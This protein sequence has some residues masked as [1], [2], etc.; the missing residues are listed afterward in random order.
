MSENHKEVQELTSGDDDQ[1]NPQQHQ[2]QINET[3]GRVEGDVNGLDQRQNREVP[4]ETNEES[5]FGNLGAGGYSEF[6]TRTMEWEPLDQGNGD[7]PQVSLTNEN[8]E[9]EMSLGTGLELKQQGLEQENQNQENE[10]VQDQ[11]QED[12]QVQDQ[13]QENQQQQYHDQEGTN[14]QQEQQLDYQDQD[15]EN[16]DDINTSTL[17]PLQPNQSFTTPLKSLPPLKDIELIT[18]PKAFSVAKDAD[19]DVPNVSSSPLITAKNTQMDPGQGGDNHPKSN[20][21]NQ[22][23]D[24]DIER[25][26]VR[27][28]LGVS[29]QDLNSLSTDVISKMHKRSIELQELKSD[30]EFLKINQEQAILIQNKKSKLL[31]LKLSKLDKLN[32]ELRQERVTLSNEKEIYIKTIGQLKDENSTIMDKLSQIEY[33]SKKYDSNYSEQIGERDQEILKL[34][35]SL[36]KLTKTN[37][38]QNQKINEVIKE[39]N[40]TRNEKFTLKLE[41]SK[42]SNELSY[43]KNQRT[44]YEEELKSVQRRFTD[45]IKKHESEFLMR[46][47]KLSSLTTKNE[48]LDRL[49]K[50]QAEHINGLQNDLEKEI[51]KASSLD[52]KFEIEKIKLDKELKNKEEL[53]ELTQ[54]QSSQRNE[55]IEQL[56]SYIE[57][58]KNKLGESINLLEADLSKKNETILVLEEKLRRTEE[59]LDKELHKET[60]LPKLSVSAEM[61][62]STK[63]D[64]ISLSSLY[65]EYNHLKKQLVLERSQKERLANQLES[66]V[67]ELESK[68]PTIANYSDQIKFYEN[69]LQEMIGKVESIRLEKLEGEKEYNKLKSRV[70][71]YN[72]DL[73]SMK[74]LCRDL[75]KQ[76]C[77]YLIHSK[78]RDSKEDPLT[79]TERKAIENILERSGNND[80]VKETDTDQLISDRLVG[81][82]NI[83]ELQQKNEGLLTVVRQLGKKLENKD[84]EFNG[85]LESAAID[86]AKD[87]ILTLENELDSVHVKLDAVSK[88]RDVLKS[89][90]DSTTK[91]GSRGELKFLTDANSDLKSKLNETE[92]VLKELQLQSSIALK[93]F[94]EKLRVVTNSKNEL[95]LNLSSIK[96]SAELAEARFANAH[97][98]L[99]NAR[100]E[101]NQYKKDI[102]FWKN[103]TSKQE[104]SLISKSNELKD[105]ENTLNEERIVINN[106]KTEKEIWN[107]Y[108]KT[109]NDDILQLRSD[110]SHLNEFV[111]NLQSLLKERESSSKELSIKLTQSIEN[112]QALRDRLSEKEERISILSNQSELALRAQNSK[113]EQ[114]N[115]L[116]LL[117]RDYKGRLAEK[118]SLVEKLSQKVQELQDSQ[119]ISSTL[120]GFKNSHDEI[121]KPNQLSQNYER[122]LER[123]LNDLRIAESQVSEFS[124]L[125]KAAELA[126]TNSTNTF[127]KYKTESESKINGLLKEKESLKSELRD[128][129]DLFNQSK[130][131]A[132]DIEKKYSN[133][134]EELK[135][136]I[137]ESI[138]KANAYDDLKKD[139]ELKFQSVAK[140]MESQSKISDENQKK[141]HEE[142]HRN[143]ELT[144][145]MDKLKS[146][147]NSLEKSIGQLTTKL[148]ST[149]LLLEKKD[150]SIEEEK[151]SIQ[152]ELDSSR[153]K[154]K[155]LQ[156][157]N[158]VLL[159]QLELSKLAC[160]TDVSEA[161]SNDDLRAVVSYLRREKDSAEAKLTS[162]FEDQQRLEQRLI[163]VTTELEATKSELSKSQSNINVT[164]GSSTNEHN[165]LLDQLQQLNILRESN[166]TLRNENS[167]NVQ[168]ISELESELQ[169]VTSKLEPLEKKVSELSMQ[170]EVKE[171][172][173]RLIK[174]ENENNRTQLE[175]NRGRD[176]AESDSEDIKAMKQRF[177][178]LKNEFQNKLLAHRSKT[179][180]LEKTVDSLRVELAN[181]KQH[182]VDAETNYTQELMNTRSNSDGLKNESLQNDKINSA[183]KEIANAYE[184]Y[185]TLKKESEVKIMSLVNEK[186][187]LE[188]ALQT[189]KAKID[190]LDSEDSN[191]KFEEKLNALKAQFEN[192]KTELKKNVQNEFDVRLKQ[193]LAKVN[194][195]LLENRTKHDKEDQTNKELEAAIKE[196]NEALEKTFQEKKSQLEDELKVKLEQKLKEKV[197]EEVSKRSSGETNGD[198]N[199]VR[200]ELIKQH[201][202]EIARLRKD[203]DTQLSKAKDDVKNVTEKKFEIKLRML[204]KKLDKLEGKNLTDR[205]VL[206]STK[207][208]VDETNKLSVSSLPATPNLAQ[209]SLQPITSQE[210]SK[211]PLGHQFTESTLTV[212]RPTIDRT[213]L[214]NKALQAQKPNVEKLGQKR[215]M[216]NKSQNTNKR[217]KE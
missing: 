41:N 135:L 25:S 56:E 9:N 89:M 95:T 92:K 42:I 36:N 58:I 75:G 124:D 90:V 50:S 35:D 174:E 18:T 88:E 125:A 129:S 116:N 216:V 207:T 181:T 192:E 17:H 147:C 170:N 7:T 48:A 102:E 156:D 51:S 49:N 6:D 198:M 104:Y 155:D 186:K 93:D 144:N 123:A 217:T 131:E 32:T 4:V 24:D 158:N 57:E 213:N 171:Q 215:P 178:N 81:F 169:S 134:V 165:R 201:E 84:D 127:E 205:S 22:G 14:L 98:S 108:Q 212:H 55:R 175:S 119:S 148:N 1:T 112:Y 94:N 61:I 20:D 150:E 72:N 153:L 34:N 59:V 2:V 45:L 52:S 28:F 162:Y 114:I 16:E 180:E 182:L 167:V 187:S 68:R 122:E 176:F 128:L 83:I 8:Q 53:L 130:Q 21:N 47:N 154:V 209:D 54:V 142:L 202:G 161:S 27:A 10:Q 33:Q 26:V 172:T 208:P 109:L 43:I 200:D 163:Q 126:L 173:I 73:V 146:Q 152:D 118:S 204:N 211:L 74:K 80:G 70:S 166:T 110:K 179:K 117:V 214:S 44:W 184:K 96:H 120:E 30:N 76:L 67:A 105:V 159:N 79:L 138:M 190:S 141:Y 143:T 11:Q 145:E 99:E 5:D 12:Q 197:D 151:Q 164:D 78:I 87:A 62:A 71:E 31:S 77:Y 97:K 37:I 19:A 91:N 23:D 195:D 210:L 65:S 206:S 40:D 103:Q 115:E 29:Q 177:T 199:L 194:S 185:D 86:E 46:S 121:G 60:D 101:I 107:L 66:F 189:L 39:L 188:S 63:A 132:I 193:E 64:G 157:Q 113:L 191:K 106:L 183:S 100:E 139:Y 140:D 136:K 203:F 69:S 149:K 196:K 82:T 3:E 38:E 111:V 137:G 160:T 133:E 13:Q 85:G 15:Q 168:R